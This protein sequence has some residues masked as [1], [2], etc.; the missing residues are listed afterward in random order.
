MMLLRSSKIF[1]QSKWSVPMWCASLN[2]RKAY[3]RIE[4]NAL[5]DAM[6]VQGVPHAYL[7]LAASLYHDQVGLIQGRQF[8]IKR[9]ETFLAHCYLMLAWSTR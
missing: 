5:F 8:P 1:V 6:K 7:K 4:Y 3:D 9:E 2:L